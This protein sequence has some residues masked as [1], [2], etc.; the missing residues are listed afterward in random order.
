MI[1]KLVVKASKL[2]TPQ[3]WCPVYISRLVSKSRLGIAC[4]A[5]SFKEIKMS[6][7]PEFSVVV[8][9]NV[10]LIKREGRIPRYNISRPTNGL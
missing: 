2:S 4:C 1:L 6:A 10:T 5:E 9:G 7:M 8:E 3:H